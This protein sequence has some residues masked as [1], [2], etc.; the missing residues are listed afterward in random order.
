LSKSDTRY[1]YSVARIRALENRLLDRSRI[2]M[3]LEAKTA[4]DVLKILSETD[5]GAV[6]ADLQDEYDYERILVA[7]RDNVISLLKKIAPN[8]KLISLLIM[9]YD[10]HNM[11]VLLKAKYLGEESDH[12]LVNAGSIDSG[13]LK[14][15][16]E[17]ENFR[18][19]PPLLRS[20]VE[21]TVAEFQKEEDP[22]VISFA[23]DKY[24]YETLT[25]LAVEQ[26][27]R[28]LIRYFQMQADLVNV[29]AYLRVKNLNKS[30]DFLE[31]VLLDNGL[32]EKRV[33]LQLFMEPEPADALIA[34]LANTDYSQIVEE[35]ANVWLKT[36]STT[37][38]EK[39]ADNF[40]M[41]FIQSAKMVV[42]GAEPLLAYL[43]AKEIEIKIIRMIM[44]SKLNGI[45]VEEI[46]ERLRDVYA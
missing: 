2:E 1:A 45:P 8:P 41:K 14:G 34:R 12:L 7:E 40:L 21:N 36:R 15:M 22:Q 17:E 10:F 32:I 29:S 3:M 11:K 5:Y 18:D 30:R 16:I 28:F 20:A 33:F 27:S 44:V 37:H 38:F 23:L 26:K 42:F 43:L 6:L 24:L 39:L 13:V 9:K 19:L 4:Q 31:G 46:K 25:A 35:G